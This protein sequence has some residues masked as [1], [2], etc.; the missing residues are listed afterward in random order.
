LIV[1]GWLIPAALA[2]LF[3]LALFLVA[4]RNTWRQIA[5]TRARRPDLSRAEFVALLRREV[6]P[7]TA[8][9]LWEQMAFLLPTIAP[10]PDDHLWNDLPIDEAEPTEDWLAEFA[11]RHGVSAQDWPDWP[12]GSPCTVRNYARWLERGLDRALSARH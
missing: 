11:D 10:H 2:A 4:F 6:R 9:F 7:E 1:P 12:A 5:R 3:V 8:E